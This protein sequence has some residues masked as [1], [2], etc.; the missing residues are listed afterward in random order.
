MRAVTVA[1]LR[2]FQPAFHIIQAHPSLLAV[3]LPGMNGSM[4]VRHLSPP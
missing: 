1:R 2:C 4:T 3:S